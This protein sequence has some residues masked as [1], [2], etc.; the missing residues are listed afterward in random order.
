[1]KSALLPTAT[2]AGHLLHRV[3]S[4]TMWLLPAL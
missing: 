2:R 1:L 4:V 3:C